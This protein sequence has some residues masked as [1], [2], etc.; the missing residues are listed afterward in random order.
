[1]NKQTLG[2]VEKVTLG[3]VEFTD[4]YI[5][6]GI[7]IK[8]VSENLQP[9]INQA[10]ED[11]KEKS[12]DIMQHFYG[13]GWKETEVKGLSLDVTV[14]RDKT[15]QTDVCVMFEEIENPEACEFGRFAIDL[16]GY[17]PELKTLV[18]ECI[19]NMFFS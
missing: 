17:E 18:L 14:N 6:I 9:K 1:M 2:T 12:T 15:L 4:D 8:E 16:S 19:G 10:I 7:N 13:R 3:N 5:Q 11:A